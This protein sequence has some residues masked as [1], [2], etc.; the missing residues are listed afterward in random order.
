ML[1]L[2]FK[3]QH[4]NDNNQQQQNQQQDQQIQQLKERVQ[5][6][7]ADNELLRSQEHQ[8]A[9]TFRR[10]QALEDKRARVQVRYFLSP[11]DGNTGIV[12]PT[13]FKKRG[14][15]C[16]LISDHESDFRWSNYHSL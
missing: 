3:M 5:Q 4:N 8:F 11:T 1:I 10:I 9:Q 14:S 13:K 16:S 6:L 12:V 15:R 7:E 2:D